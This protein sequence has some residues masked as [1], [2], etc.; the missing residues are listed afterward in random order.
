MVNNFDEFSDE[1]D[2]RM[3]HAGGYKYDSFDEQWA[4]H[5]LVTQ[6]ENDGASME[7]AAGYAIDDQEDFFL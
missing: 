1:F 6:L 7:A 5:N 3:S 2:G 4:E